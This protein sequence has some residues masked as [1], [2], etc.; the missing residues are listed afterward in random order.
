[1]DAKRMI[2]IFI[3]GVALAVVGNLMGCDNG[4]AGDD[5]TGTDGDTDVD[6]DGDSD[7][8]TD[9]DTDGVTDSDSDTDTGSESDD[10]TA[11]DCLKTEA[12]ADGCYNIEGDWYS[13]GFPHNSYYL[14]TVILTI[15][16]SQCKVESTGPQKF[17]YTYTGIMLP[18]E[19][20][21]AEDNEHEL[22]E[23]A[24][25]GDTPVFH[26]KRWGDFVGEGFFNR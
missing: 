7:G 26:A 9:S 5:D 18:M 13:A 4:G 20:Y 3:M 25:D 11:C 12:P 8:D 22:I 17:F 19:T 24:D 1:M 16:G 2:V 14:L 6:T 23:R 15:V 21:V 10:P